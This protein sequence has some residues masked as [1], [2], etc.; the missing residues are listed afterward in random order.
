MFS[1]VIVYGHVL[2]PSTLRILFEEVSHKA[3]YGFGSVLLK[4]IFGGWLVAAFQDTISQVRN[5][6]VFSLTFLIQAAGLTHC[7]AGTSEF[8]IRVFSGEESWAEY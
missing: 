5:F 1:A 6:F 7:I 8:L 4:A 2:E 3:R